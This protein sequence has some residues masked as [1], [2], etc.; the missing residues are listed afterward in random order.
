MKKI[1]KW[2]GKKIEQSTYENHKIVAE[3]DYQAGLVSVSSRHDIGSSSLN[4]KIYKA[5]GGTVLETVSYDRKTDRHNNSL[6]VITDD[7]DLGKEI[8]KIITLESL[9]N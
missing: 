3:K 9:K 6:Y 2:L 5:S 8:G 7:K 1:F 4:F